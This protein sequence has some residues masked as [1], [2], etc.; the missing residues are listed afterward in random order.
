MTLVLEPLTRMVLSWIVAVP[1]SCFKIVV[2]LERGQ[3]L[4]SV[5][6][7]TR[8]IAVIMPNVTGILDEPW[9]RYR[10]TV[11]EIE[12]RSGYTFFPLVPE[13]VRRSL[14]ARVDTGPI[15]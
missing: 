8:V 6:D 7:G 14:G 13:P 15:H 11:S 1:E 9:G 12:K 2:V 4:S 5:T 3:G 10:T